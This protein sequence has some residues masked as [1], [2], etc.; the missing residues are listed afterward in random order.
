[1]AQPMTCDANDG[2]LAAFL[3]TKLDDGDTIAVCPGHVADW[4]RMMLDAL[5]V[6]DSPATTPGADGAAPFPPGG[7]HGQGEGDGGV[8][9]GEAGATV[10]GPDDPDDGDEPPELHPAAGNGKGTRSRRPAPRQEIPA[11]SDAG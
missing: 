4:C 5:G 7:D 3:I 10:P 11:A 2:E 6:T 9:G 8:P 1:M